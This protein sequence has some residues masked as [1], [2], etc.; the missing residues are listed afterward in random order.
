M[1]NTLYIVEVHKTLSEV[2]KTISESA[3]E[4]TTLIEAKG[5]EVK[6]CTLTAY[7]ESEQIIAM[8][9]GDGAKFIFVGAD[10]T[11]QSPVP[12]IS[13]WQYKQFGRRIGW[14]GDKCV[15][16]ARETDLPYSDYKAFKTYCEILRF[17]HPGVVVPPE[18]PATLGFKWL[19]EQ[20]EWMMKSLSNDPKV[21]QAQYSTLVYEFAKNFLTSFI[22][23]ECSGEH[24]ANDADVPENIKDAARDLKANA[25]ANLTNSQAEA[26]R[27]VIHAASIACAA[28]AFVP[29]PFA[30][31]IPITSAQIYMVLELG[32]IFDNKLT[33]SDA[34]IL[35]KT[36]TAQLAGR[37][38]SKAGLALLPGLGWAINAAIAG[39][40]TE[41]LG[42]SI[43]NAFALKTR[44]Q[45]SG[46]APGAVYV[47]ETFDNAVD[48]A[49]NAV[50][51]A[52]GAAKEFLGFKSKN[53]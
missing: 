51:S 34:Q 49:K 31:A 39:T 12:D 24:N 2:D 27:N 35:L 53:K 32:T 37:A 9:F 36:F 13:S 41:A 23:G 19:D 33:K 46:A 28:I 8:V 18:P 38:L 16:F 48:A 17:D 45:G 3:Q 42:W 25:L 44:Q 40:I 50:D 29:I 4:L 6:S 30:D 47:A 43:A 20:W 5:I 1:P 15:L 11:G 26:C 52:F 7:R 10:S 21:H 22:N 14:S